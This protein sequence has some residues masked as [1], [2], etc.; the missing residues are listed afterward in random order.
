MLWMETKNLILKKAEYKDWEAMYRNV[1]SR[2]EAARYMA[3]RVTEN[4]EDARTRMQR[5]IEYQETHDTYLVY[6]KDNR[7]AVGF[8]GVDE[9]E[10][11][12]FRE[13]GIALGPE[14]VGRGYGKEILQIL[15]KY[16]EALGGKVFYYHTRVQNTASRALALS[17]GFA[18][19]SSRWETDIRNGER[20]ELQI[21]YKRLEEL[22]NV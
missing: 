22:K 5:T 19:F 8:A 16:C 1:W 9:L 6:T 12:S 20:Y 10:P 13:S 7:E 18:Y 3:W 11:Y 15:L 21:Y 14:F 17:C 2:P 4:E